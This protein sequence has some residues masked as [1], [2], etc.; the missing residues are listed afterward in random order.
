MVQVTEKP[1]KKTVILK[2]RYPSSNLEN[3]E[4]SKL[5]GN[6]HHSAKTKSPV[7]N[8][9]QENQIVLPNTK[10]TEKNVKNVKEGAKNNKN[11]RYGSNLI[12]VGSAVSSLMGN[13]MS[14]L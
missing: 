9:L 11:W 14:Q 8:N 2:D 13:K 5:S 6:S 4:S 12:V 1:T 10:E 3:V 7:E